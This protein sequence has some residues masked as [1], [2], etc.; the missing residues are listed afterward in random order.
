M[1][2]LFGK[3]L[4]ILVLISLPLI[5]NAQQETGDTSLEEQSQENRPLETNLS[6]K[7]VLFLYDDHPGSVVVQN[8]IGFQA[9]VN[10]VEARGC[11]VTVHGV[12]NEDPA[13]NTR[14][15]IVMTNGNRHTTDNLIDAGGWALDNCLD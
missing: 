2:R 10:S 1:E 14:A 12:K 9:T 13:L 3:N 7:P 4:I 11:P 15:L 6:G 5:A 8:P